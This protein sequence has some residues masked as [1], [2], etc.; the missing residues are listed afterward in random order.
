MPRQAAGEVL[1][2]RVRLLEYEG[3]VRA[4]RQQVASQRDMLSSLQQAV[5]QMSDAFGALGDGQP[6]AEP[7]LHEA[8]RGGDVAMVRALIEGGVTPDVGS[9]EIALQAAC[10]HRR[11]EAVEA[12]LDAGADV[13]ADHD[14]A[15]LWAC[16][17]GDASIVA[18]LLRRGASPG[19]L[20]GLP[21]RMAAR[22]GHVEVVKLLR[23]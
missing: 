17:S 19:A 15:L 2:L 7:P 9:L 22:L 6:H 8:A 18:L 5:M 4:L 23:N 14:S 10:Q 21:L 11:T 16:H 3:E 1:A 13:N 20:H 12:L